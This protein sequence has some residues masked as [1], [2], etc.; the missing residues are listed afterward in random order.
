MSVPPRAMVSYVWET[1]E[2]KARCLQLADSLRA[3]GIDA[4]IDRYDSTDQDD[5]VG[6]MTKAID[7][8]DY[9]LCVCTKGYH[10]RF[11]DEPEPPGVGKGARW[12]GKLI[13]NLLYG[14]SGAKAI[15]VLFSEDD[16][17]Y[18]PLP[19]QG[20]MRY[21]MERDFDALVRRLHGVSEYPAPALGPTPSFSAPTDRLPVY[22]AAVEPPR[23]QLP[24]ERLLAEICR[25]VLDR[26]NSHLTIADIRPWFDTEGMNDLEQR[27]ALSDLDDSGYIKIIAKLAT[28][29]GPPPYFELRYRGYI[30]WV[31]ISDQVERVN[32]LTKNIARR[33]VTVSND[34]PGNMAAATSQTLADEFATTNLEVCFILEAF[35][36]NNCIRLFKTIG[37]VLSHITVDSGLRKF[38]RGLPPVDA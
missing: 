36:G 32:E 10:M 5:L 21:V 3:Q 31:Q 38:V 35:E 25:I 18:I 37:V 19:L 22:D 9:V 28:G 12:E 8:S 29:G 2:H 17:H 24:E 23:S 16:V 20:A 27:D 11:M 15:P 7:S 30:Q 34:Q 6:W 26:G 33:L 1:E 14:Q 4:T 13:K